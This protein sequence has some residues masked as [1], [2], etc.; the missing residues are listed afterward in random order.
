MC[1]SAAMACK[2][3]VVRSNKENMAFTVVYLRSVQKHTKDTP[4]A[5]SHTVI[6]LV[7]VKC[8]SMWLLYLKTKGLI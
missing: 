8:R 1:A 6:N 5:A 3:K 4:L 7:C 2:I